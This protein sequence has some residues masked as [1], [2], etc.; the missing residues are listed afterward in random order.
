MQ[1]DQSTGPPTEAACAK[2]PRLVARLYAASNQALRA[3]VLQCL[4]RPLSLLG[5]VAAAA[6]AFSNMALR[7]SANEVMVRVDD[8]NHITTEQVFELAHFAQ[9]VNPGALK[10]VATLV[11]QQPLGTAAFTTAV[12]VLLHQTLSLKFQGRDSARERTRALKA[13]RTR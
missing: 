7:H 1:V 13:T 5:G 4:L 2:A 3:Q 9:Q 10:Q 6:G 12:L 8:L 11:S